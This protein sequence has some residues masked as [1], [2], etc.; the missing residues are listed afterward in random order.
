MEALKGIHALATCIFMLLVIYVT[1][2]YFSSFFTGV[3]YNLFKYIL[4]ATYIMI[5]VVVT[6]IVPA[7]IAFNE[8]PEASVLSALA[9]FGMYGMGAIIMR[10]ATP[11]A[12]VFV[13]E[14]YTGVLNSA[15][16]SGQ[17]TAAQATTGNQWIT[18]LWIVAV[19]FWLILI[20]IAAA[21]APKLFEPGIKM[22]KER[23]QE[24][25]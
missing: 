7:T 25:M 17:M 1:Y 14:G 3:T 12:Q 13:G 2:P 9:G 4:W 18:F 11:F 16:T 5:I 8:E 20:P 6:A 23:I 10:I 15:A 22:V 19:V 24:G 21:V